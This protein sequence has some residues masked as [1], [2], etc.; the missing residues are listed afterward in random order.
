M[1]GSSLRPRLPAAA[2]GF[3]HRHRGGFGPRPW[4][5]AAMGR[6]LVYLPLLIVDS[7]GV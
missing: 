2:Y 7:A 3:G 1:R 4:P 6:A 5:D